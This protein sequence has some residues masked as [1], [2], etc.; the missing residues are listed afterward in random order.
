[1][2]QNGKLHKVPADFKM[3]PSCLFISSLVYL[4]P[5]DQPVGWLDSIGKN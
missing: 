3:I 2:M 1:M 4:L 5:K